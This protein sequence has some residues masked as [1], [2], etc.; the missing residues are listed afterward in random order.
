MSQAQE[1]DYDFNHL[2]GG[3]I[4]SPVPPPY[5]VFARLRSDKP[6]LR[7]KGW[8]QDSHLVTHYD[9]VVAGMKD[10]ETFSARGNA[11]GI[12][13]VIGRTV[14]E[15]EG[16]EHLR[17]RRILTPFFSLRALRSSVEKYIEATTHELIDQFV[18]DG[19]AD[20]V[21]Q[22]TFTYPLRV[23]AQ[24]VGVPIAD[25]EAFH[26][27]ALALVSVA[28]DPVK[29]FAA[30][31][32]IVDYLRPILAE[33]R[34]G[35]AR[36]CSRAMHAEVDGERL[37]EEEVLSFL[38]LL[39]RPVR[40]DL[41]SH[42][43][44]PL[45]AALPSRATRRGRGEPRPRSRT[46][47]RRPCVGI[48]RAARFAGG[49]A[50][51][52]S[53]RI[54]HSAGR[55]RGLLDRIGQSRRAPLRGSRSLRSASIEQV[56][57]RR[58]R[59]GRALPPRLASGAPEAASRWPRCSS[60]FRPP[61]GP[62]RAC[63]IRGLRVP[64]P[65]PLAVLFGAGYEAGRG[66]TAAIRSYL[67]DG[68]FCAPWASRSS[69][70]LMRLAGNTFWHPPPLR[71]GLDAPNVP[72]PCSGPHPRQTKKPGT[73]RGTRVVGEPHLLQLAGRSLTNDS[74]GQP[75]QIA[76]QGHCLTLLR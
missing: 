16:A 61:A 12:G 2:F 15:M 72:G 63:S 74:V 7:M 68:L 40:D 71:Y 48:P 6:V 44:R 31:K 39:L 53:A 69:R 25:F 19:R 75:Y 24:M 62:R 3:S 29:A 58:L 66:A 37:S 38:R 8:M 1:H 47:S 64:L 33:R 45:R 27:W 57:S 4:M 32:F 60:D 21:P 46:S 41:P 30:A 76:S 26:H 13:I 49:H 43:Q 67:G 35:R 42:R 14:L 17:H 11:R 9:D 70:I 22:F 28:D 52:R 51:R 65:R 20:L 18:T 56:R 50:R 36:I 5:A 55:P 54:P 59:S 34:A 23:I 73:G 10:S